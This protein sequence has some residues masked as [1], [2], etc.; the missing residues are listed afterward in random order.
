MQGSR[1]GLL[2]MTAAVPVGLCFLVHTL[3]SLFLRKDRENKTG[4][5]YHIQPSMITSALEL[6]FGCNSLLELAFGSHSFVSVFCFLGHILMLLAVLQKSGKVHEAE[7]H[8]KEKKS[9]QNDF[10]F[11]SQGIWSRCYLAP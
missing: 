8:R 2:L 3:L 5:C 11:A 1:A 9:L 10:L 4:F 6:A 7:M